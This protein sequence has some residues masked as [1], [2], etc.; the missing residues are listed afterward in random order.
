MPRILPGCLP[1]VEPGSERVRRALRHGTPTVGYVLPSS[2]RRFRAA[3]GAH[4]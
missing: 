2:D 1:T 4:R 3:L